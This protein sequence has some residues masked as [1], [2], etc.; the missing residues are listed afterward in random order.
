MRIL[1]DFRQVGMGNNGGTSTIV[2]SANQL[3]EMAHK[4]TILDGGRNQFTWCSLFANH[5]RPRKNGQVPDADVVIATGYK[6]VGPTM[7]LPE[8]CGIKAHWIRAWETWVMPEEKIV[9][10]IMSQPTV[11]LVNSICLQEKLKEHGFES[12]IIRPGYDTKLLY[13][14]NLRGP[15]K[16]NIILGGLYREGVHG[17]RKR[18]KWIFDAV[19][20]IKKKYINVQLW[21]FGSERNPNNPLIDRYLRAPKMKDKNRFYNGVDIW[22]APTKSEGLHLSP[23]EAM[24]TECPVV[25]TSAEL[26]GMQ[27]YLVNGMTGLISS[28]NIKDFTDSILWLVDRPHERK[29]YGIQARTKIL[30]LGD[31]WKNMQEMVDLFENIKEK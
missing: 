9:R 14:M 25:G 15:E 8:R 12:H 13:P 18:T 17:N 28:D 22:I 10:K 29:L 19:R 30:E 4:V 2:R 7:R 31:R 20:K 5:I 24:L 27:D 21:M 23:A 16:S 1:F 11:K 6:S 3:V 26:S